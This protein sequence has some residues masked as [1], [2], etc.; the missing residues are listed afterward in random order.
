M[1]WKNI[2]RDWFNDYAKEHGVL[3]AKSER[4][5]KLRKMIDDNP[6]IFEEIMVDIRQEKILKIKNNM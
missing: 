1:S 2:S 4:K 3:V 6:E 5:Y